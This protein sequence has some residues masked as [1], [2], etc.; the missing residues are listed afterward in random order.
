MTGGIAS[1]TDSGGRPPIDGS[2]VGPAMS[3]EVGHVRSTSV[4]DVRSIHDKTTVAEWP[5][6]ERTQLRT[7]Q[8][9]Y[10]GF[11]TKLVQ[12]TIN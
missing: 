4:V 6:L 7:K 12:F 3:G 9:Y 1:T 5:L 11:N 2:A 8:F 10:I